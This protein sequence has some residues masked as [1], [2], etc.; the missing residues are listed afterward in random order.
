MIRVLRIMEYYYPDM[1]A[2]SADMQHWQVAATGVKKFG[3]K[4]PVVHSTVMLPAPYKLATFYMA[5]CR[6]CEPPLPMPFGDQEKRDEWAR[7]HSKI[8]H[9]VKVFTEER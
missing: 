1:E 7:E 6:D 9:R 3:T 8:G 5:E 2:A 4:G